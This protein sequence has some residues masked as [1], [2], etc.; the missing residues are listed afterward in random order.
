MS[1]RG[2]TTSPFACRGVCVTPHMRHRTA[3]TAAMD[4]SAA[5]N[6][7]EPLE[8]TFL[9]S[10]LNV[11]VS[12]QNVLTLAPPLRRASEAESAHPRLTH[13]TLVCNQDRPLTASQAKS[14]R[15]PPATQ[16]ETRNTPPHEQV[17][18]RHAITVSSSSP[19]SKPRATPRDSGCP[20]PTP[21][22]PSAS[23]RRAKQ[24][25]VK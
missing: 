10:D 14:V 20:A 6:Q 12:V 17:R 23:E 22:S 21:P 1:A 3:P 7:D 25:R 19:M 15:A 5:C 8:L 18:R 11:V 13:T 2:H 9:S 16:R 24:R 4:A